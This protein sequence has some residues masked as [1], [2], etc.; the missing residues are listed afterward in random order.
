[1]CL[2]DITDNVTASSTL[3]NK[4]MVQATL[5]CVHKLVF[6]AL[7]LKEFE[8]AVVDYVVLGGIML[9]AVSSERF[10]QFV[11]AL[12]YRS[13]SSFANP[14]NSYGMTWLRCVVAK[15]SGNNIELRSR[16]LTRSCIKDNIGQSALQDSQWHVIASVSSLFCASRQVME[17]LA[18]DCKS[19]LDLVSLSVAMLIKHCNDNEHNLQEIHDALTAIP[20][21]MKL[22]SYEKK[23]VQ[24]P[25]IIATYLNPQTP[26]P[27][28]LAEQMIVIE[29]VRNVLQRS[30]CAKIS[31][32]KSKDLPSE[33]SCNLLFATMFQP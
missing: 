5:S 17:S 7:V 32:T 31:S 9:R 14:P 22:Q 21:K 25:S 28:N 23:P 18:A 2:H 4:H 3:S 13:Y 29:I 11:V 19:A 27:T 26:K 15:S 8:N 6:A 1:M 12:T 10:K 30:N 24:E 16:A 20:M 33:A